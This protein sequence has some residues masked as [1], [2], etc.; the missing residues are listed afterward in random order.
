M[1]SSLCLIFGVLVRMS[2]APLANRRQ[3]VTYMK[4]ENRT[5]PTLPP[6]I[7]LSL[8]PSH[9]NEMRDHANYISYSLSGKRLKELYNINYQVTKK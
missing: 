1:V 4:C 6:E 9:E 3:H 2:L 8:V 5:K 7:L